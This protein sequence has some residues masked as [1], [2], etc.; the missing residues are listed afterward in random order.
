MMEN[1]KVIIS[2]TISV[3]IGILL[4]P[5]SLEAVDGVLSSTTLSTNVL[6]DS[7]KSILAIVPIVLVSSVIFLVIRNMWNDLGGR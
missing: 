1:V 7:V 2:G 5:I 6:T 4:L 3:V